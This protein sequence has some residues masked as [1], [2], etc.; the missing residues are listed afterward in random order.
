MICGGKVPN[1]ASFPAV[2]HSP[3]PSWIFFGEVQ[4]FFISVKSVQTFA[5][6]CTSVALGQVPRR[7]HSGGFERR[8]V[9]R[10]VVSFLILLLLAGEEG[11]GIVITARGQLWRG[12]GKESGPVERTQQRKILQGGEKTRVR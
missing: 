6:V 7:L 2:L 10:V 12:A 11:G 1:R 8:V 4:C 3:A 5:V 9:D